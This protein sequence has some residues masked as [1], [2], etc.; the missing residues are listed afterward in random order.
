MLFALSFVV[1]GQVVSAR[2]EIW[3]RISYCAR[4]N[5]ERNN[6]HKRAEAQVS[7]NILSDRP[8]V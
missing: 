6:A 3:P 7:N 8:R 4:E 2:K 1:S 5:S